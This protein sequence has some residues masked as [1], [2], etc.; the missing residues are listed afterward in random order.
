MFIEAEFYPQTFEST[1]TDKGYEWEP[2]IGGGNCT[3]VEWIVRHNPA[4][5]FMVVRGTE[6][7][8]FVAGG[9]PSLPDPYDPT[10]PVVPIPLP[11]V[12]FTKLT[13]YVNGNSASV[14]SSVIEREETI[15]GINAPLIIGPVT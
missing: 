2:L 3:F 10:E 11:A 12:T 9:Q 6:T 1:H 13:V 8:R 15:P 4:G 7:I 5:G 14:I